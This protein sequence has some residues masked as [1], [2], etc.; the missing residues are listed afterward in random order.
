P[1]LTLVGQL[2]KYRD[3]LQKCLEEQYPEEPSHIEIIIILGSPPTP[4]HK[5]QRNEGYLKQIGARYVTY[6]QLVLEAERSYK[7]YLERQ[8]RLSKLADLIDRLDHDFA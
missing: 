4:I 6:D 2:E 5:P 3:A 7:D 1:V 8:A